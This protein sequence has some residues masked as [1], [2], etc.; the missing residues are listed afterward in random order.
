MGAQQQIRKWSG[1]DSF[2]LSDC[3]AVRGRDMRRW[4]NMGMS[5]PDFAANIMENEGIALLG[6]V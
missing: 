1:D 5:V 4:Y 3:E 2:R 6:D